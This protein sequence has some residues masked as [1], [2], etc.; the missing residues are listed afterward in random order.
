MPGMGNSREKEKH[1]NIRIDDITA[2]V[3]IAWSKRKTL[4]L[5]IA[6][7]K[8]LILKVPLKTGMGQID[9]FLKR[10]EKWIRD[11]IKKFMNNMEVKDAI[12]FKDGEM[13]LLSGN[14]YPVR[15][16]DSG[17]CLEF[18]DAFLLRKDCVFIG[19]ELFMNFYRESLRRY[20]EK[21]LVD[22]SKDTGLRF[23]SVRIGNALKRW[24]SCTYDNR[25]TF[26]WLLAM[27]PPECIDYVIVHELVHTRIR[28]HGK[29]FWNEV[30]KFIPDWRQKRKWL[31]D[32]YIF[33]VA[34]S[35]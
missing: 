22:L 4:S 13:H 1:I 34:I 26:S 10:N 19:R 12:G 14:Y 24:G 30:E 6:G 31:S 7:Q 18:N 2:D 11:G 32:N 17:N 8:N 3:N 27:A 25:L 9:S 33:M 21:R 5:K 16:V 29:T 23:M 15:L 28:S 35:P 20:I